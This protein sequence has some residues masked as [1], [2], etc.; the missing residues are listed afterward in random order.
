MC[1]A[2]SL[3]TRF[4]EFCDKPVKRYSLKQD[5]KK[6]YLYKFVS[7]YIQLKNDF[8]KIMLVHLFW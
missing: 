5:D 6:N 3:N 4:L 1:G 2:L 8:F 7:F